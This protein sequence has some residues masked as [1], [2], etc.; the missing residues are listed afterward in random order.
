MA[1]IMASNGSDKI[2][3]AAARLKCVHVKS[4]LP[5]CGLIAGIVLGECKWH[6]YL[7]RQNGSHYA[8]LLSKVCNR[9]GHVKNGGR[10]NCAIL[11]TFTC[12][13]VISEYL[14]GLR[15]RLWWS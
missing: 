14:L 12:R 9:A 3:A 4:G 1:K 2:V 6:L 8:G 5:G 7:H 13:H 11:S 15:S 10:V